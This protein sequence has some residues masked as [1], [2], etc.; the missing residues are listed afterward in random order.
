MPLHDAPCPDAPCPDAPCPDA[1]CP[2]A[3]LAEPR[4][5]FRRSTNVAA[6][7]V[8][9]QITIDYIAS[10]CA[11]RALDRVVS[12]FNDPG[13]GRAW[14]ITG[15]YGTG[16]SAFVLFAAAL[17]AG[18]RHPLYAAMGSSLRAS[19]AALHDRLKRIVTSRGTLLPVLVS[20]ASESIRDAVRHASVTA[21]DSCRS[22]AAR[23]LRSQWMSDDGPGKFGSPVEGLLKLHE[24]VLAHEEGVAGTLV[25]IDELG[26]LLEF[27][28]KNPDRSDVYALQEL[29]EAACRTSSP[30]LLLGVLHQDFSAYA[31]GL[32][33]RDRQEWEKIRGRYEDI[34]FDEP[35]DQMLRLLARCVESDGPTGLDEPIWNRTIGAT[36]KGGAIPR[37][38]GK[39]EAIEILGR[40][41]P[42]HPVT[43]VVLGSVFKRYG[44][45]AFAFVQSSEPFGL[46]DF[47]ARRTA[48]PSGMYTLANLFEY[49]TSTLGDN[50]LS[51]RDGKRWAEAIDL[52]RRLVDGGPEIVTVFRT[53]A[54]LSIIGRWHDLAATTVNVELAVMPAL[55]AK[56]AAAAI[57]DLRARSVVVLRKFNDTLALWEGSDVDIESKLSAARA[58]LPPSLDVAEALTRFF[59][60]RPV[61]A[62]RHSF[63]TGTLRVFAIDYVNPQQVVSAVTRVSRGDGRILVLLGDDTS[64]TS[65][66][67][68]DAEAA[69]SPA[70]VLA[71]PA[72]SRELATLARELAAIEVVRKGTPELAGDSTARRELDARE[73]EVRR[74]LASEASVTLFGN[75][76]DGITRWFIGGKSVQVRDSKELNEQLSGV[77]DS[78]FAAAPIIRNE[79]INRMVL[80]SSAAAARRNLIEAMIARPDA[81]ELGIEGN[82]PERSVY[83]S[84]LRELGLH[85]TVSGA[86]RFVA[87]P[88]RAKNNGGALLRGI[89]EFFSTAETERKSVA[90][91]FDA[92]RSPPYG[93][94]NGVLPVILCAV[95]QAC[96]S[97]IALYED[98]AFLPQLSI[99]SFERLMKTPECFAIRR[100][101]VSGVRAAVFQQI[102]SMLGTPGESGRVGRDQVLDVVK[103]MLRFYRKLD[104]YSQTTRSLSPEATAI[105]A[106]LSTATEPDQLLFAELPQACGITPFDSND[107]CHGSDV[108]RYLTV[109]QQSLGE[110]QR[111]YDGLLSSV[112]GALSEAFAA[113]SA[114]PELRTSMV[115]RA[116]A[117]ES[118]AVDPEMRSFVVRILET[119]TDDRQWVESLAALLVSKPPPAWRDE[120]RARFEVALAQRVRRLRSLEVVAREHASAPDSGP[121]SMT[122]RLAVA[123]SALKDHEVVLHVSNSQSADVF[124]LANALHS[125][126]IALKN[127]YSH[128]IVLAAL[129]QLVDQ[130]IGSEAGVTAA[131]GGVR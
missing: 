1:P 81:I 78:V 57:A 23:R 77:C 83:L 126:L 74:R 79:I 103:P 16:K 66:L 109:L 96:E 49:M 119:T 53:I 12:G 41:W 15:P 107:L 35:A 117:I 113:P 17:L 93:L 52:D 90:A 72:N 75:A 65:P 95:L 104:Q 24:C 106:V 98:G 68:S 22:A 39:T 114:L 60:P 4:H 9:Q 121:G 25:V 38:L 108:A 44:Q 88:R 3:P 14:T 129:A 94:R 116:R 101:R 127:G 18:N 82:P 62:R 33:A 6:D 61:I 118:V 8:R 42:L 73:S 69:R 50:L 99:E 97:E 26:K 11:C 13:L 7:S 48:S 63:E 86:C 31:Q 124:E 130:V 28:A 125:H 80:S 30:M 37:G 45:N 19:D 105:R 91:F 102:A 10:P 70:V 40:C 115:S 46:R 59:K 36:Q 47:A 110:L 92:L 84:V 27:A 131:T 5:A 100:W 55:D 85:T 21:L 32:P 54:M 34:L 123:G 56:A 71:V 2:D 122:F 112:Q 51:N 89:H 20:G 64:H 67:T 76:R 58:S 29:A 43:A 120:D 87:D 128:G 111:A